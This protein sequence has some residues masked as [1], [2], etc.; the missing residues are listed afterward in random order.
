MKRIEVG[1][2]R[3]PTFY[4]MKAMTYLAIASGAKGIFYYTFHG[5]QYFIKDSPEHWESLKTIVKE[6]K[7]IYPLL[8]ASEIKDF[9][10]GSTE[11][12]DEK[13]SLFWT[14]R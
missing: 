5:S 10:I 3:E 4:E 12:G 8:V 11:D 6:L 7:T 1:W 13:E 2:K 14:V 9:K